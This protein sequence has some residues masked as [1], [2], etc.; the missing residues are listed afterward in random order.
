MQI[1]DLFP[2]AI[3]HFKYENGFS[4]AELNFIFNQKTRLNTGNTTSINNYILEDKS[5]KN[6]KNFVDAC[7]KE[8]FESIYKPQYDVKPYIT[9]SWINYT[10]PNE[11][12]HKHEHPNSFISGCIYIDADIDADRIYFFKNKYEQVQIQPKEFNF[13]NSESWWLSINKCDVILFPSS[14][15]HMVQ[16]VEQ[17]EKRKQR[18]SIAFNTFL[19]GIIGDDLSLTELRM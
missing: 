7:V 13:Y 12:H 4:D 8:Y 2:T 1:I 6:I 3:G 18:I 14:L 10:K 5:L 17:S 15:T 9:Q 19:T 11:F 16:M